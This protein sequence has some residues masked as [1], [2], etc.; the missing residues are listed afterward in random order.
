MSLKSLIL[1]DDFSDDSSTSR[2]RG[3]YGV[4]VHHVIEGHLNV[5]GRGLWLL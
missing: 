2:V 4:A 1:N 5:V 3:L